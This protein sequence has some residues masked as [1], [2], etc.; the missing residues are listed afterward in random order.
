MPPVG[1]LTKPEKVL[2]NYTRDRIYSQIK[3]NQGTTFTDLQAR[4]DYFDRIE[5]GHSTLR[6]HLDILERSGYINSLWD[7]KRVYYYTTDFKIPRRPRLTE[8]EEIVLSAIVEDP[9]SSGK[10]LAAKTGRAAS[11]ISYYVKRLVELGVAR[12]E[13]KGKRAEVYKVE[14]ES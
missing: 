5:I 8:V 1:L 13:R 4:L 6:H 3:S 10:E 7:R 11:T 9:A 2:D 12:I 14:N